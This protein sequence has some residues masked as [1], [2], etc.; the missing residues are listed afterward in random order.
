MAI[1][2]LVL[3]S[4]TTCVEVILLLS[5]SS[6]L[7]TVRCIHEWI[8]EGDFVVI[9][10]SWYSPVNLCGAVELTLVVVISRFWAALLRMWSRGSDFVVVLGEV[11]DSPTSCK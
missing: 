9:K 2:K 6:R 11:W 4:P 10:S 8:L 7:G 5:T 1:I 3:D